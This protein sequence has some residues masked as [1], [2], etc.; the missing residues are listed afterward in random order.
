MLEERRKREEEQAR[1]DR[2][3]E[4]QAEEKRR[5]AQLLAEEERAMEEQSRL[6][7]LRSQ[8]MSAIKSRVQSRWLQPADGLTGACRVH[9]RQSPSGNILDVRVESSSSCN[10]LM[11]RSVEKAVERASP[12]PAPPDRRVFDP[13]IDFTFEPQT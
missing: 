6:A 4:E 12:L 1:R 2:I 3:L 7:S 8:Y 9:V 11:K 5:M 13:E 10:P